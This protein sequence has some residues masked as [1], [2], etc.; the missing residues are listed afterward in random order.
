[1]GLSN[2][3]GTFRIAHSDFL[4]KYEFFNQAIEH[5]KE[6]NIYVTD[7]GEGQIEVFTS[8]LKPL[9]HFGSLGNKDGEFQYIVD[10]VIDQEQIFV[11]D[12]MLGRIQVFDLMGKYLYKIDTSAPMD[13]YLSYPTLITISNHEKIFVIDLMNQGKIFSLKGQYLGPIQGLGDLF[14]DETGMNFGFS[15]M[16]SDAKGNVFLMINCGQD[17]CPG[18]LVLKPNGEMY[19][20]DPYMSYLPVSE[21]LGGHGWFDMDGSDL[22]VF[23]EGSFL[24][25]QI[26]YNPLEVMNGEELFKVEQNA[27][28]YDLWDNQFGGMSIQNKLITFLDTKENTIYSYD[29]KG[30]PI[31]QFESPKSFFESPKNCITDQTDRFLVSDSGA[32]KVLALDPKCFCLQNIGIPND[33]RDLPQKGEF[34]SP[35]GM[36][37][38]KNGFLYVTDFHYGCIHVFDSYNQPFFTIYPLEKLK[39]PCAVE[40]NSKGEL[41]V[42]CQ[43]LNYD[44]ARN[45]GNNEESSSISIFDIKQIQ[46]KIFKKIRTFHTTSRGRTFTLD[47]EDRIIITVD[48]EEDIAFIYSPKG[49][50]L[51]TLKFQTLLEKKNFY[52]PRSVCKDPEKN[53]IV[54]DYWRGYCWKFK[55][56]GALLWQE[57]LDWFGIED[58]FMDSTGI[59]C[60]VDTVHNVILV[61][62]DSSVTKTSNNEIFPDRNLKVSAF[63]PPDRLPLKESYICGVSMND[64]LEEMYVSED[65]TKDLMISSQ[66]SKGRFWKYQIDKNG[67]QKSSTIYNFPFIKSH[68]LVDGQ[69]LLLGYDWENRN[70]YQL[71]W[72]GMD[73]SPKKVI[74]YQLPGDLGNYYP[75]T[76]ITE[77]QKGNILIFFTYRDSKNQNSEQMTIQLKINLN[78]EILEKKAITGNA[79][80]INTI[81][82]EGVLFSRIWTEYKQIGLSLIHLGFED[83]NSW[84]K[85]YGIPISDEEINIQYNTETFLLPDGSIVIK[86]SFNTGAGNKQKTYGL[87]CKSDS[88]GN[89]LWMK[90]IKYPFSQFYTYSQDFR[91]TSSGEIFGSILRNKEDSPEEL[92]FIKLDENGN[93]IQNRQMEPQVFSYPILACDDQDPSN[94]LCYGITRQYAYM[95]NSVVI[96]KLPANNRFYQLSDLKVEFESIEIKEG[97]KYPFEKPKFI[98]FQ[99]NV[100]AQIGDAIKSSPIN[101]LIKFKK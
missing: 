98:D 51:D 59:L 28:Q 35:H 61:L 8:N 83:K 70:Q 4:T 101:P 40:I 86:G 34:Y 25:F 90:K 55:P 80:S 65:G 88:E 66:H 68:K 23:M 45:L 58:I 37:R 22:Y 56:N 54:M 13:E 31:Y 100:E 24:L 2:Q 60:A 57:S 5:D 18:I 1:M 30:N 47:K 53:L 71:A 62:T 91:S 7:S 26:N 16:K 6:G 9:R 39:N 14:G 63:Y 64:S 27:N 32:S 82:K 43:G 76:K 93:V 11:L 33:Y 95:D 15:E 46:K 19:S 67:S 92:F 49:Q 10:L 72:I 44:F 3:I 69:F 74:K 87:I 12:M 84:S 52:K 17:G 36:V 50:F 21:Y 97:G 73:G 77:D 99:V 20:E 48:P 75:Y 85:V 81:T 38:D 94:I 96:S 79:Y 89:M 41:V 78:G 42:F 29:L